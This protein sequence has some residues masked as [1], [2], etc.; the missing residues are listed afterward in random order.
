MH[1]LLKLLRCRCKS[2]CTDVEVDVSIGARDS[3]EVAQ[4]VRQPVT[5]LTSHTP[6]K[7]QFEAVTY[8]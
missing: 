5:V 6:A 7:T 2:K 1:W 3:I 8:L 4:A